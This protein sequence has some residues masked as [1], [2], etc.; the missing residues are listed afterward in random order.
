MLKKSMSELDKIKSL[1]L[2]KNEMAAGVINANS[3]SD[4]CV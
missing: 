1:F 2:L 4:N 3:F